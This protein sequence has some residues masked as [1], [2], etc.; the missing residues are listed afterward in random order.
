MVYF[1]MD[2]TIKGEQWMAFHWVFE[3]RMYTIA[4]KSERESMWIDENERIEEPK[5]RN[6]TRIT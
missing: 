3:T 4:Q 2:Y 6:T 5:A 1:D